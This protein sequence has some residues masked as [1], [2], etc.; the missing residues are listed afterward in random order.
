MVFLLF[1]CHW[2]YVFWSP[3]HW[4]SVV[5]LILRVCMMLSCPW[6]PFCC[7]LAPEG[8]CCLLITEGL[9]C[10]SLSLRVFLLFHCHWGPVCCLVVPGGLQLKV[11]VQMWK[12]DW[13]TTNLLWFGIFEA[14]HTCYTKNKIVTC[15]QT[16]TVT[17]TDSHTHTH[18]HTHLHMPACSPS[19]FAVICYFWSSTCYTENKIFTHAQTHTVTH[20]DA[21]THTHMHTPTC[22]HIHIRGR[23]IILIAVYHNSLKAKIW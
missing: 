12:F 20:T 23:K 15:A 22:T 2:G 18:T 14:V 5:C 8:L 9:C 7:F 16:H 13:C 6:M 19:S 10:V 3:C 21:H 11:T 4:R 17:H 1:H